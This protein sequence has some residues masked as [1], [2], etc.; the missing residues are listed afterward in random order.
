MRL[1]GFRCALCVSLVAVATAIGGCSVGEEVQRQAGQVAE[2]V[3]DEARQRAEEAA[4]QALDDI[5]KAAATS[6][7]TLVSAFSSK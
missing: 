2:S 7:V 1:R 3:L 4:Q 6:S 5:T